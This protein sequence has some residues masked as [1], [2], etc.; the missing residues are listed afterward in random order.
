ML[1][2]R[3]TAA[4]LG[5]FLLFSLSPSKGY[6]ERYVTY[7][8]EGEDEYKVLFE[9]PHDWSDLGEDVEGFYDIKLSNNFKDQ[10]CMYF[11]GQI[12]SSFSQSDLLNI[13]KDLEDQY[14]A[15]KFV[16]NHHLAFNEQMYWHTFE[17]FEKDSPHLAAIV[18]YTIKNFI[19][20]MIVESNT[21]EKD[22]VD[23]CN[24]LIQ[25]ASVLQN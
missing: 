19:F 15:K 4:V 22:L 11:F 5:L 1:K 12:D 8:F 7:I 9:Y 13:G 17:V 21:S 10:T 2:K 6:A 20:A 16:S 18:V 25:K 24:M 23:T 3:I 14:Y